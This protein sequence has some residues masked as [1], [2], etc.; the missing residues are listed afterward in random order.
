MFCEMVTKDQ[1]VHYIWGLIQLHH[2]FNAGKLNMQQLQRCASN[3][4]LQWGISM[5]A[6]MLDASLT[7]ANCPLHLSGHAGP[8]EPVIQETQCL[9]VALM[10]SIMVTSINGNYPVSLGNH[11]LQNFLQFTS[12]GEAMVKGSLVKC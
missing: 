3:D 10:P 5:N 8:S 7:A 1:K 9:L 6:F 12:G 2:C 11:W 4:Q